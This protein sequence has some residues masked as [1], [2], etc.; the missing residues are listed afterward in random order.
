M[1]LTR[2]THHNESLSV[3]IT[4]FANNIANYVNHVLYTIPYINEI[5]FVQNSTTVIF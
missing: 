2:A 5:S 1:L 3:L 4:E